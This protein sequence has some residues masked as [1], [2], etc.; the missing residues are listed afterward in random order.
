MLIESVFTV[1]DCGH[2]EMALN[3]KDFQYVKLSGQTLRKLPGDVHGIDF[4]IDSLENCKVFILDYSAQV[5]PASR[6]PVLY[7]CVTGP[8]R[9]QQ[10]LPFRNR[11]R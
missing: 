10:Q 8:N 5:K 11:P 6:A 7:Q 4:T 3:P 2:C 9:R 1:V